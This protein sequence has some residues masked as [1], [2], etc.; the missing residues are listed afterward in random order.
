M[1]KESRILD[2]PNLKNDYYLNIVDWGNSNLLA[3]AL[4]SDVYTLNISNFAV[5]KLLHIVS[6]NDYPTSLSWS[7]DS[8]TLAIGHM[9][10]E[11][12]LWDAEA[13]KPI[14]I[15]RG[16]QEKVGSIAWNGSILT[17]GSYD[18]A[19][20]NHD[21]RARN[22]LTCHM[23][24]HTG[25]VCGLKWS[26]TGNILASGGNDNRVYIWH[27]SK[28][29]SSACNYMYC[30]KEHTAAVKALA[31]CPYNYDV[32]ASGGGTKDGCIKL[33]NLQKG[34]CIN[35]I[36]TKTQI[37]G[38]LWNRHHKEILS[39]HGYGFHRTE[40][41]NQICLWKYP[42][43]TKIGTSM[44]HSSR[45]LH[46]SQSPDGLTVVS[47]GADETIRLWKIFGPPK[48]EKESRSGSLDSLL[49]LKE[50]P[51]R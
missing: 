35:S 17:S 30:L 10:S 8:K 36:S 38:L 34:T 51:I 20:V 12:H 2:A 32:L 6:E 25:E 14:R 22:S 19:I 1:Q 29:S 44:H 16:H 41:Q 9:C 3:V 28:M 23:K 42:S 15:L 21:V 5:C 26:P 49:S 37:S 7:Q 39:G 24:V 13:S 11:I 31:W 50:S 43:M 48:I 27:A 45:V 18:R 4:G 47:A 40:L 33:W 46:L